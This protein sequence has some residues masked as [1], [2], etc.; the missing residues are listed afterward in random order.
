[1]LC[2]AHTDSWHVRIYRGLIKGLLQRR[3]KPA[4]RH[5]SRRPEEIKNHAP[6]AAARGGSG[7][8]RAAFA[9]A[10]S[11]LYEGAGVMRAAGGVHRPA[12]TRLLP[13]PSS[14]EGQ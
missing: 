5:T 7:V 3:E 11:G 2:S 1:M 9:S 13:L 12:L 10:P 4:S 14:G 6:Y 8:S